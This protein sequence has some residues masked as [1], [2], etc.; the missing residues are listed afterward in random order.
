MSQIIEQRLLEI[1]K[2]VKG[3]LK[4]KGMCQELSDL[5][6]EERILKRN[7]SLEKG[8][9][10]AVPIEWK[11][12]WDTGAD[13]PHVLADGYRVFLVYYLPLVGTNWDG[14]YVNVRNT[15]S[16]KEDLIALVEFIGVV[17]FT[18]GGPNEE[19]LHGHPLYEHG[20]E[21]FSAHE[22][23]NSKWIAEQEKINAV[24]SCHNPERWK[25]LKHYALTFHDE[26]FECIAEEY[27][28][29]VVKGRFK[30][31]VFEATKRLFDK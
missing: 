21:R 7:L 6:N 15:G 1:E 24:H 2:K 30:D 29:D 11:Y 23:I 16:N 18:F 27:N 14:T 3:L 25:V 4:T 22:I 19:V 9:E 5:W 26:M 8:E 13:C 10:T 20:L 31:V 28:V 12:L 17:N